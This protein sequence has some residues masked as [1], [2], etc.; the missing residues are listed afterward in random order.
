MY[1]GTHT[2]R[3]SPSVFHGDFGAA[4]EGGAVLF[5]GHLKKSFGPIFI[6]T[7]GFMTQN[8]NALME[9]SFRAVLDSLPC[10]VVVVDK[11]FNLLYAN[12]TLTGV[13]GDAAEKTCHMYLK[14]L[15]EPCNPCLVAETIADKKIHLG[16]GVLRLPDQ[17]EQRIINCTSPLLDIL[18]NVMAV[19]KIAFNIDQIKNV[20]QELIFL[21]E[22]IALLSHDIKN[23]LEGLQGGAYVVDEGIKDNDMKLAS[24]GWHVVRKN[25]SDISRVTQNIL[26]SAKKREPEIKYV[27]P[28]RVAKDV[29]N[30]YREK[31]DLMGIQLIHEINWK[32]PTVKMDPVSISRMLGNLVWNAIEACDRNQKKI[33]GVV[34]IR[35]DY[36]SRDQFMFEVED[37]G[38]GMEDA[39]C[40]NLF[41]DFFSNKGNAG[42]GLGLVVVDRI[43]KQHRGR[44]D[45]LTRPGV[46]SLFRVIFNIA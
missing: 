24:K 23:I 28:G 26:F 36:Y 5:R 44:I 35:T 2:A 3:W 41:K 18:G 38:M 39:T 7:G 10:Y 21:G 32:F 29:Y 42:T 43:V 45:I 14:N 31:A 25:I 6:V 11:E 9:L 13:F 30:L 4:S 22:S 15:S 1:P 34:Y 19:I 16:E 20:Q 12:Q 37:N 8:L 46:G 17:S 40:D 33:A 27:R